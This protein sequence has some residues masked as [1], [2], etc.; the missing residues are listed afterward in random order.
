M[1]DDRADIHLD[2]T[3]TGRLDEAVPSSHLTPL[4]RLHSYRVAGGDPDV[5]GWLVLGADG[6][7]IGEVDDLL[8]DTESLRV[9]YLDVT[10]DPDLLGDAPIPEAATA[11][12]G[13]PAAA[14]G[15]LPLFNP[16]DTMGGVGGSSSISEMFARSTI[17]ATEN[18]LT[19]ESPRGD[20]TRH[21]LLPIGKAR[22]D[23][24]HDRVVAEG[25]RAADALGLPDYHGQS[26][27][28]DYETGLRQRFDRGYSHSTEHDFYAHDLYDQDR[29][30]GPRRQSGRVAGLEAG[31]GEPAAQDR[32]AR[33]R[34]ITGELDRSVPHEPHEDATLPVRGR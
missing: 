22:L 13:E 27:S 26:V 17:S 24:E 9:R 8:V 10:L 33:N 16:A 21:V 32:A 19:R 11:G 29:F 1:N 2:R 7:K 30:Y 25:L 18:E 5:R 23:P 31:H 6:R 28:R 20:D 12:I 3:P 14:A 15:G 4:R 34:E